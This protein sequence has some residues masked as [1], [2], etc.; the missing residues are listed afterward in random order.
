M[1]GLFPG[2]EKMPINELVYKTLLTEHK[3]DPEYAVK[4]IEANWHN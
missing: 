4:C 3:F 2:Q 1:E